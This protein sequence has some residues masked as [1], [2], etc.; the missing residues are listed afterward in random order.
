MIERSKAFRLSPNSAKNHGETSE[1]I[2]NN[3][4]GVQNKVNQQLNNNDVSPV[5]SLRQPAQLSIGNKSAKQ[6]Y[7]YFEKGLRKSGNKVIDFTEKT[8]N[9][10]ADLSAKPFVRQQAASLKVL[11]GNPISQNKK[12][13]RESYELMF[14]RVPF[15]MFGV[16]NYPTTWVEAITPRCIK[17]GIFDTRQKFNSIFLNPLSRLG[18]KIGKIG[19]KIESKFYSSEKY[20]K[21]LHNRRNKWSNFREK[22]SG[23]INK[24]SNQINRKWQFGR[25]N[26]SYPSSK[27]PSKLM[28]LPQKNRQLLEELKNVS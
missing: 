10:I 27:K 3:I 7:N 9:G 17:E 2:K 16:L 21:K 26:E 23:R 5:F 25:F 24:L 11:S 22:T 28:T 8:T 19:R 18:K 6:S 14:P 15:K 13:A 1:S 12:E 20:A 4:F